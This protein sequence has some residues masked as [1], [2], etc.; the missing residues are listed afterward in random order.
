MCDEASTGNKYFQIWR[1][2]KSG[3]FTFV[4]LGRFPSGVQSVSF[5]DMGKSSITSIKEGDL[6]FLLSLIDRDGTMDLV[7]TTCSSVS[8]SSGIGSGCS[9][10]IAYNQQLPLCTSTA[11]SGLKGGDRYCRQPDDLC[12]ADPNFK[13]DLTDSASNDVCF[14]NALVTFILTIRRHSSA[15][16]SLTYSLQLPAAR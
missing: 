2:D 16:P 10:N 14:K 1:N 6:S 12:T 8:S 3:D 15:S 9:V 11:T 7:F 5:A 4:Q 13:F